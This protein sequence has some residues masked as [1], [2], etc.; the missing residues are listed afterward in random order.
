M[1]HVPLWIGYVGLA[2]SMIF[3]GSFLAGQLWVAI[4]LLIPLFALVVIENR[5]ERGVMETRRG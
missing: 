5:Y 4:V 1:P 2:L 3:C